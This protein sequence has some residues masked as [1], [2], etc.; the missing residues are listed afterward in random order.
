MCCLAFC[1]QRHA[2]YAICYLEHTGVEGTE[3][4][5]DRIIAKLD[6]IVDEEIDF[7]IENG[8]RSDF[9]ER[10]EDLAEAAEWIDTD[11]DNP[12]VAT[13]A[14]KLAWANAYLATY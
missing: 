10:A 1:C 2:A 11:L 13:I 12:L 14:Y 4:I 7:A 6:Q 8:G 9:I 3:D 5:V